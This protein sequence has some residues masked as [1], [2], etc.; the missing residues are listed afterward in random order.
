[1]LA[2]IEGDSTHFGILIS[3]G[4]NVE[5]ANSAGETAHHLV[6]GIAAAIFELDQNLA[7]ANV[8]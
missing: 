3:R 8:S 1:M 5:K 4:A 7:L 2:A 6:A